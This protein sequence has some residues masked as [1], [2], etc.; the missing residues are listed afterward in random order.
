ME[1]HVPISDHEKEKRP[2]IEDKTENNSDILPER[3]PIIFF[4]VGVVPYIT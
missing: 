1:L 2:D 4:V 3:P